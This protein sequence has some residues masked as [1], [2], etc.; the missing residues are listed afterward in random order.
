MSLVK[1]KKIF[2]LLVTFLGW[3]GSKIF[4]TSL[5]EVK[6]ITYKHA[7][8]WDYTQFVLINFIISPHQ[9]FL[10]PSLRTASHLFF[11]F[12]NIKKISPLAFDTQKNDFRVSFWTIFRGIA[13][14]TKTQKNPRPRL[15]TAF[16]RTDPLEAKDRNAQGQGQGL[17]T[18]PQVFSK[19][20]VF[21]KVF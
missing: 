10:D 9:N 16:P 17:R 18:Q 19:K 1:F 13:L 8:F 4:P 11:K 20:K 2:Y 7:K 6:N 3:D 14:S 21:K 12:S 15:R 5:R